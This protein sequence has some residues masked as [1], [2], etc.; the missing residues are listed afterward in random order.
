M[1]KGKNQ[2]VHKFDASLKDLAVKCMFNKIHTVVEESV[3]DYPND[4]LILLYDTMFQL[5]DFYASALIMRHRC[6]IDEPIIPVA[7][8]LHERKF[9][10]THLTFMK[11]VFEQLPTAVTTGT[12][13]VV[14]ITDREFDFQSLT[15]NLN[16]VYCWRHLIENLKRQINQVLSLPKDLQNI[17]IDNIYSILKMH[18]SDLAEQKAT[19]YSE[20]WPQSFTDYYYTSLAPAIRGSRRLVLE[21]LQMFSLMSGVTT[22]A[23]ESFNN[24]IK[25]WTNRREMPLD[26]AIVTFYNLFDYYIIPLVQMQEPPPFVP[27]DVNAQMRLSQYY[28]AKNLVTLMP[29]KQVFIVED[30]KNKYL[31][32]FE[33]YTCTCGV[34]QCHHILAAR[35]S[36]GLKTKVKRTKNITTLWKQEKRK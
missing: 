29:D 32:Q 31:V 20:N 7:I 15:P 27:G 36:C 18:T 1:R 22:N 8:L 14:F 9:V 21:P 11:W 19:E 24:V 16:H 17:I 35:I 13:Q 28:V 12:T 25:S 2:F 5:G 10:W 3:T 34:H 4:P 26:I 6:I 30:S 23:S 33:P